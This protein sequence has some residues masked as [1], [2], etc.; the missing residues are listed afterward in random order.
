TAGL[1]VQPGR[2]VREVVAGDA[3]D[4]GVAQAHLADGLRDAARLVPVQGVRLAGGDVAEVA[5]AGALVTADEEGGLAV[6]SA[7]V[8][9]GAVGLLAHGV[10][11]RTGD[12]LLDRLVLR[13]RLRGGADPGRLV[14]DGRLGVFRLDAQQTAAFG[15]GRHAHHPTDRAERPGGC[16][17]AQR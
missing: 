10:Q 9:V 13:T 8:H 2:A 14:L 6:L 7:L 1:G 3:G 5:A 17:P 15:C 4:G 12:A 11:G 16:R